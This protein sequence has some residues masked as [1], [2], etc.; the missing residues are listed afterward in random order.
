MLIFC[1]SWV[2]RPRGQFQGVTP[3]SWLLMSLCLTTKAAFFLWALEDVR[4]DYYL[5][6]QHIAPHL[7]PELL[8]SLDEIKDQTKTNG[9]EARVDAIYHALDKI[10]T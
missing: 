9:I 4:Y 2:V 1:Q 8:V 7:C 6:R 3:S 5:I 10:C